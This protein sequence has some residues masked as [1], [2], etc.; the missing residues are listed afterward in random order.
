MNNKY[1]LSPILS[2]LFLV[3]FIS[4]LCNSRA[5]AYT[6]SG[7]EH[8]PYIATTYEELRALMAGAPADYS[9]CYI[10]LGAD[11]L[12]QDTLNDHY[13]CL[14]DSKQVVKLDLNG[15]TL[16]RD[17]EKT[18]DYE[19]ISLKL[20]TIY[21]NDSVGTG[22]IHYGGA[23]M[24]AVYLD[25]GDKGTAIIE[26][27]LFSPVENYNKNKGSAIET[28]GSGSLIIRGGT[29]IGATAI[30]HGGGS[31]FINDGDF[32]TTSDNKIA[33]YLGSSAGTVKLVR[34]NSY[35][36]ILMTGNGNNNLWDYLYSAKSEVFVDD[37]K[38]TDPGTGE[39][40]WTCSK[41]IRI[42]TNILN[43][44]S[45]DITGITPPVYG[46]TP[47]KLSYHIPDSAP[48]EV[49]T[50]NG[51]PL[52]EWWQ[53]NAEY[54]EKEYFDEQTEYTVRIHVTAK[55]GAFG[56]DLT[57]SVNGNKASC[58]SISGDEKIV[59]YTFPET[60][61]DPRKI[62]V[63][64]CNPGNTIAD[65]QCIIDSGYFT[66]AVIEHWYE[67][68][69]PFECST[70]NLLS[71]SE[72][73]VSDKSYAV[74]IRVSY[75]N[76]E[77]KDSNDSMIIPIINGNEGKIGASDNGD[78]LWTVII[79][80]E[81]K[82]FV[83]QP[84]DV[85]VH[86]GEKLPV[87]FELNFVPYYQGNA[88]LVDI[89]AYNEETNDWLAISPAEMTGGTITAQNT[90]TTYRCRIKARTDS[91][92]TIYSNEFTATWTDHTHKFSDIWSKNE[93]THW[94][95]CSC[96]EKAYIAPHSAGDWITDTP[97]GKTTPGSKHK[98]CTVCG[99]VMET[100]EIPPYE[101]PHTH[102]YN[103][104]WKNNETSHWHECSCGD[105][106][107]IAAHTAGDWITD[108][109]ATAIADGSRHKECT[110]C[111]YVMETAVIPK[112]TSSTEPGSNPSSGNGGGSS[113]GSN[114]SSTPA[115]IG[116]II[117]D[118]SGNSYKVTGGD[119]NNPT[120]AFTKP[121]NKAKGKFTVPDRVKIGNVTYKVTSIAANAFK[122][123]KKI[124]KV[125][126]GSNV[127]T[128]GKKAFYGCSRLT[129]VTIG[130]NVTSIGAS[131]FENCKK[132]KTITIKS[133]KLKTVGKKAFKKIHSKA[134]IKV[135]KKKLK[136]YKKLLNNKG[137]SKNVVIK[138]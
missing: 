69:N 128:I 16:T 97:A 95:E 67:T 77:Y 108:K 104:A 131:A 105:K 65:T 84:K 2:F 48:Y 17:T 55:N 78:K 86:V 63:V 20:G 68:D 46:Q 110:V 19:V 125:T 113:S 132:L 107:D 127:T 26:G 54:T 15:H 4:I 93:S 116:S 130:K 60:E 91:T 35:G 29:F 96:G 82:K 136:P 87:D 12:E 89:Q 49:M 18:I 133:S 44:L 30:S 56:S 80:A 101:A 76:N 138:S 79:K 126:I 134:V 99:Y 81:D 27:G 70:E 62:T 112:D 47:D 31:L 53:G 114:N 119:T 24:N 88:E 39:N 123:N 106:K 34:C 120:V 3:S 92:N 41:M 109:A 52:I 94:T 40:K 7:L 124:T 64:G 61:A 45:I 73:I 23:L 9:A 135:P 121:K 115:A 6:G 111:G 57:C 83:K 1:K 59:Y 21:I 98:E 28:M 50:D 74:Q 72:K 11:I 122:N 51:V 25:I 90:P 117:T 37:V 118:K 10:S 103:S 32:Y 5:A 129:A 58:R 71:G 8:D 100:A 33:I 22:A 14:T 66:K 42:N 36:D 85:T 38:H 13:L 137:Q 102:S 75:L 43:N